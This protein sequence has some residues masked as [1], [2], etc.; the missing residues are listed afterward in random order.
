MAWSWSITHAVAWCGFKSLLS[1]T[2]GW[3]GEQF[4]PLWDISTFFNPKIHDTSL[5]MLPCKSHGTQ[6]GLV[7]LVVGPAI[8]CTH[9]LVALY[10]SAASMSCSHH[11]NNKYLHELFKNIIGFQRSVE[12]IYQYIFQRDTFKPKR[13]WT[14]IILVTSFKEQL[15]STINVRPW[16]Y[17]FLK[18]YLAAN[19]CIPEFGLRFFSCYGNAGI[20]YS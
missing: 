9:T 14:I 3:K 20:C 16:G 4:L 18:L 12:L 7:W 8:S 19:P 2:N 10:W 6:A 17:T 1:A 13:F 11:P 15:Q 5:P